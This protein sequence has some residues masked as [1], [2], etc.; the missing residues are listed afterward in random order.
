MKK[1]IVM[2]FMAISAISSSALGQTSVNLPRVNILG[3]EYY[4]YE[5]KKGDSVYGVAKKFEWDPAELLHLN[6]NTALSMEKGARLYYPTGRYD[7]VTA[8]GTDLSRIAYEPVTHVV[9]K[10]ETAYS[11]AH[12][13]DIS[14]DALYQTH[15]S[16]RYGVKPGEVIEIG[17]VPE[18]GGKEKY[19]YYNLRA[20]ESLS[21]VA[22]NYDTTVEALMKA[23][24]GLTDRRVRPGTVMRVEVGSREE[25]K[26]TET[27]TRQEL[28][29]ID[30]YKIKKGDTWKSI[31]NSTGVEIDELTAANPG[32]KLKKDAVIAVPKIGEVEVEEQTVRIDPRELTPEGR[33]EIY[34]SLHKVDNQIASH[35]VNVA[36]VLDDPSSKR[37]IEFSRGVLLALDGMKK[38]GVRVNLKMI[39]GREG[40]AAVERQLDAL[41]PHVVFTTADKNY[42][43][44]LAEYG[45]RNKA[46]IVNVF[47]VKN[48]LYIDNPS[49]VQVQPPSQYF[50]DAVIEYLTGR[51]SDRHLVMAGESDPQDAIANGVVRDFNPG[52]TIETSVSYLPEIDI[53][54]GED[55]L[56][57]C[58]ATKRDE[59]TAAVQAVETLTRDNP[60]SRITLIGRPSWVMMTDEI[61]GHTTL[62]DVRI[63]S[64][65]Y[66]DPAAE[67]SK[68]FAGD[69]QKMFGEA[70]AKSFPMY[71]ASGHDAAASFIPGMVWNQGDLNSGLPPTDTLQA[72]IE[73]ERVS[74]WGG[75]FNS[76]CYMLRF[77]PYGTIEKER[78]K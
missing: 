19:M 50:N 59:V 32:A 17:Q 7:E 66:Y 47:N 34:D 39:D 29:S 28:E 10:G 72:D 53:A 62:A 20:G 48:E 78:L 63:P 74:N 76:A 8:P 12:L 75:F 67:S 43:D 18:P 16:A 52:N 30:S 24:P 31:A 11:I 73:P 5:V 77:T 71:A 38:S 61:S 21:D 13:Y 4:Y 41:A 55:Y 57:Y 23:N 9:K 42:P 37:D 46:E 22:K 56:I 26:T 64:R 70:P 58:H 14:L 60:G 65:F 35:S 54:D 44:Y 6:P 51:Y 2:A 15:P 33:Q 27:V 36:V 45:N 40:Q 68:S 69:F 25:D 1:K 49:M 3:K